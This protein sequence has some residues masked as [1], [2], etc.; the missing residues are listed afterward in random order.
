M[1]VYILSGNT[2]VRGCHIEVY[3]NSEQGRI[4][5]E[6]RK[7]VLEDWNLGWNLEFKPFKVK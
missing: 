1:M 3:E 2:G 5:G 4:R 6:K 7:K